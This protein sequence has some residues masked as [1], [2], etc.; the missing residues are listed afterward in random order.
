[1]KRGDVPW[2]CGELG[3]E[4]AVEQVCRQ[5]PLSA[6]VAAGS[7]QHRGGPGLRS[8][9]VIWHAAAVDYDFLISPAELQLR[10]AP[11]IGIRALGFGAGDMPFDDWRRLASD[12]VQ[13]LIGLDALPVTYRG[14]REL[15]RLTDDDGVDVSA[16]EMV[17]DDGLSIP[18]YF[19]TPSG[20]TTPPKTVVLALHG[21]GEVEACMNIETVFEDYHHRFAHR[22]AKV[23]HAVLLPELRGF[24]ALYNLA[25]QGQGSGL[26]YWRWGQPMAYTLQMDAI[27]RGRSMMGDT[28]GD[29][30][31][32]ESWLSEERGVDAIDVVGISWGG[33]LAIT[34]PIFS[35]RVRSIFASGTLGS[36]EPVFQTCGNAPAPCIPGV[37][38]WLDR[39]D[40]AGLNA[41]TPIAVHYGELDTPGQGNVSASNN[42]TVPA[43]VAQLRAVYAAEGTGGP[44]ELLISAGLVHEMDLDACAD[45]LAAR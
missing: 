26:T 22:L 3:A 14:V 2:R 13:E 10:Y 37:L 4:R 6:T 18:A 27:S 25:A 21:H 24:G 19:L 36:F 34:Y 44:V 35:D 20:T 30:L 43:S 38:Q 12:K 33:D 23:G 31:R 1:V 17:V 45:W 40:I 28:I 41:P 15:R 32:W 5:R 29:L 11:P 16:I 39:A 42:E 8:A 7:G 9:D